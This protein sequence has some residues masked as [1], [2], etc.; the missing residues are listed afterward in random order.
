MYRT[1]ERIDI[2]H[3]TVAELHVPEDGAVGGSS[4]RCDVPDFTLRPLS[5]GSEQ[6]DEGAELMPSCL[7]LPPFFEVFG[8]FAAAEILSHRRVELAH[9]RESA[10]IH[11]PHGKSG[12]RII[13]ARSHLH[14]H[15][16]PRSS[17]ISAPRS[18]RIPLQSGEAVSRQKEYPCIRIDFPLAVVDGVG[19]DEGI[20]V[21]IFGRRSQCCRSQE[22]LQVIHRETI[23]EVRFA[24]IHPPGVDLLS[25]T[26]IKGLVHLTPEH[27]P[28]AFGIRIIE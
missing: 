12:H 18:C 16:I 13:E 11:S 2:W 6:R 24:G 23:P 14:P 27:L 3:Q 10:D 28:S 15:V 26:A 25:V 20:C 22:P 1:G 17:D 4:F 21:E 7:K 9:H 5:V 19:I 8:F